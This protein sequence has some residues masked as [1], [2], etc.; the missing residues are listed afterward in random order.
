MSSPKFAAVARQLLVRQRL[1][2]ANQRAGDLAARPPFA[3]AILHGL[4][5]HVV[6]VGPER[7]E[8]SAMVGHVAVPVGRALPDAHRRQMGRLQGRHLPLVDPVIGDAIQPDLAVRPAL[9]AGPLD[10][11]VEVAR[12][13]RREMI[14]MAGRPP[15]AAQIDANAGIAMRHPLLGVDHFPVLVLV[16]RAMRRRRGGWRSWP[17]RRWDSRSERRALWR[18]DHRSGAPAIA[19]P[20]W[21][22]T[23]PRA[24]PGRR[25]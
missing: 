13:A 14:D 4:D 22:G 7:R 1:V 9:D 20:P 12:L 10:A 15:G 6:P 23:R 5:L 18:R 16:G 21:D 8:N 11:S 3:Q 25:P 19:P 17:A 2:A 24:T